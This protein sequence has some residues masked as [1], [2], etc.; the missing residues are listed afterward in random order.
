MKKTDYQKKKCII[1]GAGETGSFIIENSSKVFDYD[2]H[3]FIDDDLKKKGRYLKNIKIYHSTELK[4]ILQNNNISKIFIS[5]LNLSTFQKQQIYENLKNLSVDYEYLNEQSKGNENINKIDFQKEDILKIHSNNLK[6]KISGKTVLVTGAAGTIGEELCFQLIEHSKLLIAVDKNELG[7]SNLISKF[8]LAGKNNFKVYLA[9]LLN[10]ENFEKI[11]DNHKPDFIFHAAAYKH[12]EIC[13]EN[14]FEAAANNCVGIY[15]VLLASKK[16][17]VPNFTFI[18]TDKAVNP[19]NIMGKTKRFGEFLV[20]YFSKKNFVINQNYINV[21]FGNVL[22]SSGSLIPKIRKQIESG[23]KVSITHKE[24]TRYFMTISDAVSLVLESSFLNKN[25]KTFVLKMGRPIN[26][27]N[28]A[29]ELI[30]EYKV[31]QN[32]KTDIDIKII[33]L[34]PGEKLHEELCHEGFREETENKNIFIDSKKFNLEINLEEK[35]ND[36]KNVCARKD[37]PQLNDFFKF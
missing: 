30:N 33:G 11:V 8:T 25:S 19:L 2:V 29:L 10:Y 20:K 16:F 34:R 23:S 32:K 9:N 14:P 31:F 4:E 28:L 6:E 24:A 7:V 26:I 15:N 21:R 18:S 1:Y 22:N 12:V 36:L 13:E 37:L 27:Y 5:I 3:C 35:I 17:N